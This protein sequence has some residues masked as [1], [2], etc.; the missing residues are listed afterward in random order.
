MCVL[1]FLS[2]SLFSSSLFVLTTTAI[3]CCCRCCYC[4]YYYS[5]NIGENVT[6]QAQEIFDALARTLPCRWNDQVIVVLDEIS[7]APP[8]TDP[9]GGDDGFRERIKNVLLHERRRLG[10]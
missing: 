6:E 2:H 1:A 4:Y 7:I 8:Y 10:M 3:C 5:D 9:T